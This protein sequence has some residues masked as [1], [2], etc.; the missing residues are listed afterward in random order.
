[1][2]LTV[3]A[4]HNVLLDHLSSLD[5]KYQYPGVWL[6][7]ELTNL[8]IVFGNGTNIESYLSSMESRLSNIE[9]YLF[10]IEEDTDNIKTYVTRIYR[11]MD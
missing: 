5:F 4:K 10:W 2:A 1:M 3:S 6:G 11:N 7:P 8:Y 9:V